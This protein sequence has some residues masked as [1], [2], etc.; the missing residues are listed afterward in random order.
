MLGSHDVSPNV[1]AEL[2]S[3][4][5]TLSTSRSIRRVENPSGM[6]DALITEAEYEE[7]RRLLKATQADT[8][9]AAPGRYHGQ[10]KQNPA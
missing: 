1:V 10:S 5:W 4:A 9:P 6:S 8:V 7:K 2:R 3:K